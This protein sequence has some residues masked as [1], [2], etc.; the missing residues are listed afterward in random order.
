MGPWQSSP[1][2]HDIGK[3]RKTLKPKETDACVICGQAGLDSGRNTVTEL[4]EETKK[5]VRGYCV[6]WEGVTPGDGLSDGYS[7]TK[8]KA[9][10]LKDAIDSEE[11]SHCSPV[12]K[13]QSCLDAVRNRTTIQRARGQVADFLR[14]QKEEETGCGEAMSNDA[15]A[16]VP[17]T[18]RP[19][20]RSQLPSATTQRGRTGLCAL[21]GNGG[22]VHRLCEKG[23]IRNM[24]VATRYHRLHQ[25]PDFHDRSGIIG[26]QFMHLD[27][28]QPEDEI[29]NHVLASDMEVHNTC[30]L[31]YC[32]SAGV[33]L[34]AA[35]KGESTRNKKNRVMMGIC[36]YLRDALINDSDGSVR[37]GVK[38]SDSYELYEEGMKNRPG[39]LPVYRKQI[40]R[41]YNE[42]VAPTTNRGT[43]LVCTMDEKARTKGGYFSL[44]TSKHDAL[45]FLCRQEEKTRELQDDMETLQTLKLSSLDPTVQQSFHVTATVMRTAFRQV[46]Y[47]HGVTTAAGVT[48]EEAQRC[49]GGAVFTDFLYDCFCDTEEYGT[50]K[51]ENPEL[52]RRCQSIAQDMCFAATGMFS[53]VPE[54]AALSYRCS[55]NVLVMDRR[56][57]CV[58]QLTTYPKS[59]TPS[60]LCVSLPLVRCADMMVTIFSLQGS[61]IQEVLCGED[62]SR[63]FT[64]PLS[65]I[66]LETFEGRAMRATPTKDRRD[67]IYLTAA[68]S[69]FLKLILLNEARDEK[70]TVSELAQYELAPLPF[71]LCSP[72]GEPHSTQK[73]KLLHKVLTEDTVVSRVERAPGET[74]ALV[75]DLMKV[76][77]ASV[78][79]KGTMKTFGDLVRRIVNTCFKYAK[80]HGC[81]TMYLVSDVYKEEPTIKNGC[82]RQRA[83]QAQ[84]D[85]LHELKLAMSL[86]APRKLAQGFLR[87]AS[88]KTLLLQLLLDNFSAAAA[89]HDQEVRLMIGDKGWLW[90]K[91]VQCAQCPEL[92]CAEFDE[93]DQRMMVAIRHFGTTHPVCGSVIVVT[94]DTDVCV[95]LISLHEHLL[96]PS[97]K[98][99]VLRGGSNLRLHDVVKAARLMDE[100]GG[101]GV[102]S[103]LL[104]V[105]VL[106]GCD[107]TSG[108]YGRSKVKAFD[109]LM[110]MNKEGTGEAASVRDAL[111]SAGNEDHVNVTEEAGHAD[112]SQ[113]FVGG[114][115]KF[116]CKLYGRDAETVNEAR[117]QLWGEGRSN[118]AKLPPTSHTLG[119][120]LLRVFF[121]MIIWMRTLRYSSD[122]GVYAPK[123]YTPQQFG[124][125]DNCAPVWTEKDAAPSALL[126]AVHCKSCTTG[127]TTRRCKCVKNGMKCSKLCTCES[128]H[129]QA[130]VSAGMEQDIQEEVLARVVADG[131]V[132]EEEGEGGGDA[133]ILVSDYGESCEE[134]DGHEA[135]VSSDDADDEMGVEATED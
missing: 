109:C 119:W 25:H 38:V 70:I 88:N 4:T 77:L 10:R 110:K 12:W 83:G 62:R 115:E 120:H 66:G 19:R 129:N 48:E 17:D 118:P 31:K 67:V 128:C 104:P 33:Y 11:A 36:E 58:S 16:A 6:Q 57:T 20:T 49:G 2:R 81:S 59:P 123:K 100:K 43:E 15:G 29:R 72:M 97:H 63:P 90:N 130:V 79:K 51:R 93:A 78:A 7:Q 30:R 116:V 45:L 18:P 112:L 94:E 96:P 126:E 134:D 50:G 117:E 64:E 75:I 135:D 32:R 9:L 54:P 121:Q 122:P 73:H 106:T 82:H 46:Q 44:Q 113:S 95:A 105:H 92:N 127:C 37:Y 24:V 39:N 98:L 114:A 53:L 108:F 69:C 60:Y 99:Y 14:K 107:T 74:T 89:D 65:K 8:R 91:Q 40:V 85:K 80:D 3:K 13:H 56:R 55:I 84:H 52:K 131:D 101:Q 26:S 133:G 86:P 22:D 111:R 61:Q 34:P 71:S 35:P 27:D 47:T 41:M 68:A 28:D 87:V 132:E 21:C 76:V 23:S 125:D 102:H 103:L 124:W 5:S 42:N 1:P